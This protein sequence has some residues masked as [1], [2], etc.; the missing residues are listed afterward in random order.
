MT[1]VN[2]RNIN[3]LVK[4]LKDIRGDPVRFVR[5]ILGAEPEPWQLQVLEAAVTERAVA[6]RSCHGAGKSTLLAWL[7]LYEV[8]TGGVDT[9][10]PCSAPSLHQL[11]DV[12]WAEIKKWLMNSEFS[13]LI[14]SNTERVFWSGQSDVCY[15]VARTSVREHSRQS[16]LAGFHARNLRFVL[17]EAS[18]IL[19]KDFEVVMGALTTE[20][21]R[22]IMAGNPASLNGDFYD[23]FHRDAANWK[24]FH[25]C[26]PVSEDERPA[27][28]LISD[29][30]DPQ[31]ISSMAEKYGKSSGVYQI[32]VL[33]EFPSQSEE[34]AIPL[35]WV[36]AAFHRTLDP[37]NDFIFGV[38][39]GGGNAETT[40]A[41]RQ[42]D[43]ALELHGWRGE[44]MET[45]GRVLQ[46][47]RAYEPTCVN[48]DGFGLGIYATD[49][50]KE[51]MREHDLSVEVIAIGPKTEPQEPEIYSRVTD[52][53]WG[54]LRERLRSGNIDMSAL[55]NDDRLLAQLTTRSYSTDSSGRWR[56][57]K[58]QEM[59]RRGLPSPDR[60]D[61]L[62]LAFYKPKIKEPLSFA[63]F[64]GTGNLLNLG[65]I[66]VGRF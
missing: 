59:A 4:Y 52:E 50:L 60:A 46:L 33:G 30:V 37:G 27:G 2:S 51:L 25:I 17:D 57:E 19:P 44:P 42:G 32:R 9:K 10:V 45:V 48:C 64:Y 14:E 21:A 35:D 13:D 18:G 54:H 62:A 1:K 31:Y 43:V 34:M 53:I 36:V 23:A 29:R 16:N 61:A 58:K 28:A 7:I 12:L 3:K 55:Q 20:N 24:A 15:A 63:D 11:R 41:I 26:A 39:W 22:V 49:R 6:I 47:I 65:G 38:D 56:L 66:R 40:V 8:I 5:E